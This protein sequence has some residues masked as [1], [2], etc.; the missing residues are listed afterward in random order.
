M[1]H[2]IILAIDPALKKIE[3][4]LL[5]KNR[6]LTSVIFTL[7]NITMWLLYSFNIRTYCTLSSIALLCHFLDAYR[8]KIKR[9]VRI[10]NRT[11]LFG[12]N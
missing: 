2:E 11:G 1:V 8:N 12:L 5:W 6:V 7:C 10:N 3:E 4:I 9:K